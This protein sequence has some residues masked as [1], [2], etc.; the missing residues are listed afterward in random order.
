MRAGVDDFDGVVER[1]GTG[2]KGRFHGIDALAPAVRRMLGIQIPDCG[3][4]A[5]GD[6]L[7]GKPT[8]E[9]HER[10]HNHGGGEPEVPGDT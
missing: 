6:P 8:G 10:G 5:G 7:G 2:E 9:G 4:G 1:V 3:A